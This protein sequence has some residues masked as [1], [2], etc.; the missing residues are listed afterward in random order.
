MLVLGRQVQPKMLKCQFFSSFFLFSTVFP[1]TYRGKKEEKCQFLLYV[2]RCKGKTNIC[3]FFSFFY[4]EP[5]P[6]IKIILFIKFLY[7]FYWSGK[8][9]CVQNILREVCWLGWAI[10][11]SSG[12]QRL[13]PSPLPPCISTYP[14]GQ[15]LHTVVS[16]FSLSPCRVHVYPCSTTDQVF[17]LEL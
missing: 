7:I 17:Q 4:Y 16:F 2:G 5:F 8:G 12:L 11:D 13:S 15:L 6:A 3:Q 9:K 10:R 1:A 14:A